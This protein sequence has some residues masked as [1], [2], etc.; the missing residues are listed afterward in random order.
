MQPQT[1]QHAPTDSNRQAEL[2][3]KYKV[4]EILLEKGI[5]ALLIAIVGFWLSR[6]LESDKQ[7]KVTSNKLTENKIQTI[8][9]QL[10]QFYYP[11]CFG[12]EKDNAIW[13]LSDRLSK[14]K[15]VVLPKVANDTVEAYLIQNHTKIVSII[16]NNIHLIQMDDQLQQS[17]N[18]YI[19]HVTVYSMIRKFPS[20]KNYKPISFRTEFP[21]KLIPTIKQR[22][23]KLEKEH[24]RLIDPKM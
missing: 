16:E 4:K 22:I 11:V 1:S 9:K 3:H 21:K 20:L 5:L 2:Q 23:E 8:E 13:P 19:R 12:L 18:A 14:D 10:S 7:D 6:T 15:N 24:N 17:L